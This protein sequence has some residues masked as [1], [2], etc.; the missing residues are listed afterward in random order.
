[1]FIKFFKS[2][3]IIFIFFFQ[4]P[5]YSKNSDN[6]YFYLKNLS[7]YFSALTYY[8]NGENTKSL[9]FFNKSKSLI[10]KHDPYLKKYIFS[11]IEEGKINIAIKELK[12]NQNKK[13]SNF[14]ESY[15]ILMLDSI[16]NKDFKKSNIYQ[17]KLASFIDNDTF[18]LL[19]FES[20]KKYNYLFQNKDILKEKGSFGNLSYV[21]KAFE[22]CY[23]DNQSQTLAAFTNLINNPDIDYSRYIFF[24][25]NYL[26]EQ[27]KFKE[28]E[29]VLD[30]VEALNSSL[31]IFQTKNWIENKE[32]KKINKVFSC[33]NELDILGEFLFLIANLYSGQQNFNKANFYLHLSIFLNPKFE[34]NLSLMAENYYL[35]GNYAKS[36][37]ILNSYDINDGIYYWYK[38][39]KKADII[40]KEKNSRKS[41]KYLNSNFKKI[42]EPSIK[43]VYDMAN[44]S[45]NYK[46]YE[47]AIDH[48]NKVLKNIDSSSIIYADVLYRRGSSYERLK[49]Y[50]KSDKDLIESL[51]INPDDAYVL[52]YLAYSWLERN[53]KIKEAI[54]MLEK[55]FDI[56]SDDPFILDSVGWAY[57]L[58]DDLIKAEAFLRRAI[59]L[60]PDD[61]IVN[62]HYG[63]ILWK[64]NRKIEA[65]YYWKS[66][67]KF[68]DTD[69]E[70]KSDVNNK[71]LRGLKKI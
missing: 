41:F 20:L 2:I 23:L 21:I 54:K 17:D 69:E 67:L 11:L 30:Q 53:Y 27:N 65:K 60:M 48:Y 9:D 50:E 15:M 44:L 55:A 5:L 22:N 61:P 49:E 52:N 10:N 14:F 42:K 19:I 28:A 35:N 25:V 56:K 70:M 47:I 37:R 39:K 4:N 16:K 46:E 63:D 43:I 59:Q 68:K 6:N 34:F 31:L 29:E 36:N 24:Y 8:N 32:F 58:T 26:F 13:N 33:K 3:A 51:K 1:M 71:I 62:D 7:E 57:Y 45:K 12:K 66:V 18:N 40:L 64:M 38:I